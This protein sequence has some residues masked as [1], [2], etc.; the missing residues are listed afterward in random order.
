VDMCASMGLMVVWP[1]VTI[2]MSELGV[3]IYGFVVTAVGAMVVRL[4]VNYKILLA[5]SLRSM[6]IGGGAVLWGVGHPVWGWFFISVGVRKVSYC[7]YGAML[8]EAMVVRVSVNLQML[9]A[10]SSKL[11]FIGGG[12]IFVV[13][14]LFG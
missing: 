9:L 5:I 14:L 13:V 6:C 2:V 3:S 7:G 1:G 8:E 12:A 10:M 4:A 11:M